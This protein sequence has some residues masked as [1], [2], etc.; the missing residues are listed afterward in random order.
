M[1][2]LKP[3]HVVAHLPS[4]DQQVGGLAPTET[5]D[6][7]TTRS[8][9][10]LPKLERGSKGKNAEHCGTVVPIYKILV[11]RTEVLYRLEKISVS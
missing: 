11:L 9:R 6:T 3:C 2:E 8:P 1:T 10:D 7:S 5:S 4:G